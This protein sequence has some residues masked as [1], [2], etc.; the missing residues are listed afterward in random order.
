[1]RR[2]E[3]CFLLSY[4]V[5]P[6]KGNCSQYQQCLVAISGSVLEISPD[7]FLI[8]TESESAATR[9]VQSTHQEWDF[10]KVTANTIWA[11][12]VFLEFSLT[13]NVKNFSRTF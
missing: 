9:P 4:C 13:L 8:Q 1:M 12:A 11:A 6:E 5:I 7:K 10:Q 3:I 2:N